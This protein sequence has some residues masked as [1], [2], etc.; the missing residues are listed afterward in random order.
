MLAFL[1]PPNARKDRSGDD[2]PDRPG[3]R[4]CWMTYAFAT[5]RLAL[6]PVRLCVDLWSTLLGFL[7]W[8]D[9]PGPRIMIGSAIGIVTGSI[10]LSRDRRSRKSRSALSDAI[11]WAV[12]Q[13]KT[14]S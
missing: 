12:P 14:A 3:C 11:W 7:I 1:G 2:R 5:P 6:A 8:S 13:L 9:L 4:S 10:H